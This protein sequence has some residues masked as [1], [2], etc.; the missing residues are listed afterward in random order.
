[1]TRIALTF[2]LAAT[3]A[4]C[5]S[6]YPRVDAAFGKSQAQMIQA[7]T[8]DPQAAAHPPALA[9]ALADGQRLENVL[10]EHRKDIPQ[11]A[12]KQ[13]SQTAQFDV[14]NGQ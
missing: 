13:V 9:P 1:M 7:Q 2:L 11:Q 12:T 5:A 4:A 6:D 8:Y 10:A 14:G 3:L